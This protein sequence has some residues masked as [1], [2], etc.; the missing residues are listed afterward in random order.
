MSDKTD[1]LV[2]MRVDE[3]LVA[4]VLKEKIEEAVGVAL[5]DKELVVS[6]LIDKCLNLRVDPSNGKVSDYR[7][8]V[9]YVEYAATAAIR[10]AVEIA[11]HETLA[12][13]KAALQKQ[14]A[15]QIARS[16]NKLAKA[17]VDGLG[18]SLKSHWSSTIT[19]R[20]SDK[21]KD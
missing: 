18:E 6:R 5:I 8:A 20:L 2:S 10:S 4:S 12:K 16:T 14:V 17:L 3:T 13:R 7:N 15:T 9:P 21:D 19:V 11:M 1:T